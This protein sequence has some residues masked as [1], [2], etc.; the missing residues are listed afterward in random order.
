MGPDHKKKS[1]AILSI[2]T[3]FGLIWILFSLDLLS[4]GT[5]MLILISYSSIQ[6]VSAYS[7][8]HTDLGPKTTVM[9]NTDAFLPT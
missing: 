7:E 1:D 8:L 5:A 9:N 6:H 3:S 4:Q 2:R